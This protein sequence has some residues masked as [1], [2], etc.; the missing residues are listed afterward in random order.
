MIKVFRE[1]KVLKVPVSLMKDQ[2]FV[3]DY[4]NK[5]F[6]EVKTLEGWFVEPSSSAVSLIISENIQF[7]AGVFELHE[8]L[9]KEAYEKGK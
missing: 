6:R 2:G 1:K 7:D 4:P 3:L 9:F 8:K 5:V